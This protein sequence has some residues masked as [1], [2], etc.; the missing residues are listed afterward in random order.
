MPLP[1]IIAD[2]NRSLAERGQL[3][4]ENE[5][6]KSEIEKTR[7]DLKNEDIEKEVLKAR[8]IMDRVLKRE[9]AELTTLNCT[10]DT[11]DIK[12]HLPRRKAS[13]AMRVDTTIP[14]GMVE[15]LKK[16]GMRL[17][18]AG[19]T[20]AEWTKH[21]LWLAYATRFDQTPIMFFMPD[22]YEALEKLTGVR[23]DY[24]LAESV[25]GDI[26]F[27]VVGLYHEEQPLGPFWEFG[28][29]IP[30]GV[31]DRVK[32]L[33]SFARAAEL[34]MLAHKNA[35]LS[36]LNESV[37]YLTTHRDCVRRVGRVLKVDMEDHD[38]TK[39]RLVQLALGYMWHYTGDKSNRNPI[40]M[41]LAR[42]A[43]SA[44][45][46]EMENHHPEYKGHLEC[47]K[48][49]AD[50][51]AVHMQKDPPDLDGG[52]LLDPRFIPAQCRTQWEI[53]REKHRHLNMYALVWNPMQ[54][55]D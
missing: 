8:G 13:K 45:H 3:T 33:L 50:R 22:M 6:L 35:W 2:V 4:K 21:P 31:S 40:L 11:P 20:S 38:L 42:D 53:F 10:A 39:T 43:I 18:A 52:W 1:D 25:S 47:E 34:D 27:Y 12:I 49:F 44:G 15:A 5:L 48:M 19:T 28:K 30:E 26:R 16:S 23:V 54:S 14:Q 46:L 9:D 51:L 7:R 36:S 32:R 29:S 41:D 17:R 37:K 24:R 55:R